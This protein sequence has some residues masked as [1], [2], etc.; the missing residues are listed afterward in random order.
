MTPFPDRA[1]ERE[2]L[3]LLRE[4]NMMLKQITQALS[5]NNSPARDFLINVLANWTADDL[6][7]R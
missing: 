2:M 7:G 5:A 6:S 1:N 4:N 3:R